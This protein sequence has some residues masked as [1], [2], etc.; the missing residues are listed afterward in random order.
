MG[1]K[2]ENP[3]KV[4]GNGGIYEIEGGY[5]GYAIPP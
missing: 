2:W 4:G 1:S 5:G 3:N